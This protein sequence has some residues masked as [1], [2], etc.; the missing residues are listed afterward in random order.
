MEPKMKSLLLLTTLLLSSQVFANEQVTCR[1]SQAIQ[2]GQSNLS[3]DAEITFNLDRAEKALTNFL[4]H[5]FVKSPF[6]E[7]NTI[8][9]E[10]SYMGFF[11]IDS[12]SANPNYRP[13]RYKGFTQFAGVNAT[14]TTGQEDGMWGEF[15]MDLRAGSKFEAKYIFKAGDHM[16][17]VVFFNCRS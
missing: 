9:T 13:M 14:H 7:G 2:G 17:G 8:S 10:N 11:S 12:L 16:G 4:G 1:G 6:D 3:A 5:I 15:V